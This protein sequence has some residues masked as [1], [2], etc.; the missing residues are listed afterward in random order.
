VA[1]LV[2]LEIVE[3]QMLD[4]LVAADLEVAVLDK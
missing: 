1:V 3:A 2:L 4:R